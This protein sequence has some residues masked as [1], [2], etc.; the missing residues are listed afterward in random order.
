MEA[1]DP[2]RVV[3]NLH[4]RTVRETGTGLWGDVNIFSRGKAVV[5]SLC[6]NWIHKRRGVAL[7]LRYLTF[8][9][10]ANVIRI[11]QADV[12]DTASKLEIGL[13]DLRVSFRVL[14]RVLH[15]SRPG[16]NRRS[17]VAPVEKIVEGKPAAVGDLL[18]GFNDKMWVLV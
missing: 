14:G 4:V 18:G 16:V 13:E 5:D 8:D 17:L 15:K 2:L 1:S 10:N 7:L 6:D 11:L 12:H 9:I 3:L